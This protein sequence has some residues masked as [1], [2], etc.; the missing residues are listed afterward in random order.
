MPFMRENSIDACTFYLNEVL[1]DLAKGLNAIHWND[2]MRSV[3]KLEILLGRT[4]SYSIEITILKCIIHAFGDNTSQAKFTW[5]CVHPIYCTVVYRFSVC[6]RCSRLADVAFSYNTET[7]QFQ[8]FTIG[9]IKLIALFPSN[10][11]ERYLLL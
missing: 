1:C 2:M 11:S 6:L 5:K 7:E 3:C 8:H 10:S 4:T 9:E